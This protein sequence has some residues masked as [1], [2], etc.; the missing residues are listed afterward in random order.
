MDIAPQLSRWPAVR[1]ISGGAQAA[2]YASSSSISQGLHIE[3][4]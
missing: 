1:A 4:P 2:T 3:L